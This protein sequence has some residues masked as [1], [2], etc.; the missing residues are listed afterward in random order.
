MEPYSN[1]RYLYPPRPEIKSTPKGIPTYERMGFI[2]QPKLNGSAGVI[3]STPLSAKMM[4]R[5]HKAFAKSLLNEKDLQT[6][7]T[8]SGYQVLIG[9]YMNKSKKDKHGT[10]N[11]VFVIFDILVH[12][13]IYLTGKTF[14]E[15]S[16]LIS[17]LYPGSY[18]DGFIE[19]INDK[20][21]KVKNFKSNF[22]A[23]YEEIIKIDMYEGWVLKKP[24]SKLESGFHPGN[25]K[26]W[27]LK[28]RKPTKNYSY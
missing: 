3:F 25:N 8:G 15:R 7:H 27:Q 14:Q 2:G 1:F 28:I 19:K 4:N 16:D 11:G 9:E 12:N 6:I 21:Y 20:F 26:G 18:H 24:Q 10:F 22:T 17:R 5:H 13:G 23:L